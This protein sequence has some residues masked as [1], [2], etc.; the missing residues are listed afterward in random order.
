M[1]KSTLIGLAVIITALGSTAASAQPR[2]PTPGGPGFNGVG[3]VSGGGFLQGGVNNFDNVPASQEPFTE[4]LRTLRPV[5]QP[6]PASLSEISSG[7]QVRDRDVALLGTIVSV[8]QTVAIVRYRGTNTVPVPL[9]AFWKLDG[10]LIL[11]V[12]RTD[13]GRIAAAYAARTE[14]EA[15]DDQAE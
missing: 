7:A 3:G 9:S 13:F 10:H 1:G 11:G 12:T 5:S 2:P 15:T 6:R 4:T 14:D 8:D